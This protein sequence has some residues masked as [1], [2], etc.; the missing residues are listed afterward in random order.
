[1]NTNDVHIENFTSLP[2]EVLFCRMYLEV[3]FFEIGFHKIGEF[4]LKIAFASDCVRHLNTFRKSHLVSNGDYLGVVSKHS[5]AEC[6]DNQRG[7]DN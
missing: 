7:H 1:M 6:A 3:C 4:R 5:W 2:R